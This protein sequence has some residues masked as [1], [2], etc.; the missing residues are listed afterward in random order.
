MKYKLS[1]LFIIKSIILRFLI[2]SLLYLVLMFG[3][4]KLK[5][6][7]S[8]N[9]LNEV[10]NNNLWILHSS[11][12]VIFIISVIICPI[13]KYFKWSYF[14]FS[15]FIEIRYGVLFK[16]YICIKRDNI[17]Y[18]NICENPI[19]MILRIKSINIYTAGGKVGIPAINKEQ[20]EF[21]N[22]IVQER[23]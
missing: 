23:V 14:I 5:I 1:K 17:K 19:D 10:I 3:F 13:I 20:V 7:S 22:Y 2:F 16:R 18:I 11:I 4:Y 21:F 12:I 8:F 9:Q 15:D 6:F